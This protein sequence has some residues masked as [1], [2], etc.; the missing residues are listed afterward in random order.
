MKVLIAGSV[1]ELFQLN[2]AITKN[3]DFCYY[4]Y[5]HHYNRVSSRV[6]I[7][8]AKYIRK[9]FN[10]KVLI[11]REDCVGTSRVPIKQVWK[12]KVESK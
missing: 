8:K 5:E 10:E 3:G 11:Q 2:P 1:K 12:E 4:S 7:I 9:L 6:R